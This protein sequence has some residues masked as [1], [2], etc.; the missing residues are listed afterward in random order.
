MVYLN[1]EQIAAASKT[2]LETALS[3]ATAQ[4]AVMEKLAAIQ[5]S[6]IKALFEETLE[7]TRALAS[8]KSMQEIASLQKAFAQPAVEKTIAYSKS[9][10]AVAIEANTE[11]STLVQSKGAELKQDF[12]ALLAQA[13][14]NAPGGNDAGAAAVKSMLAAANSAFDAFTKTANQARELADANVSAVTKR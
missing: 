5:S 12:A 10:Y 6:T 7:H 4:F 2:N 9:M 3:I 8:A 14:K 11:L 1:A 13:G